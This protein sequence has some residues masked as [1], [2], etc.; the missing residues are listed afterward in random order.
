MALV[1]NLRQEKSLCGCLRCSQVLFSSEWTKLNFYEDNARSLVNKLLRSYWRMFSFSLI[2]CEVANSCKLYLFQPEH[3]TGLE[4]SVRRPGLEMV[5]CCAAIR[6]HGRHGDLWF[7]VWFADINTV[8]RYK[9]RYS[10]TN[11]NS[12]LHAYC[13]RK[14]DSHCQEKIIN[15]S[16]TA[17]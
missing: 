9:T 2:F 13:F 8:N 7:G 6:E 16:E 17:P 4:N 11:R 14:R 5:H 1:Q 12:I 3:F 15:I 10:T